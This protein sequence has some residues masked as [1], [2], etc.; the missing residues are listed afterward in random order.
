MR[1]VS[2]PKPVYTEGGGRGVRVGPE[3]MLRRSVLSCLLWEKAFYEDGVPIVERIKA[4]V[5]M[6]DPEICASLAIEARHEQK[7]RHVPLAIALEMVEHV[8]HKAHVSSVLEAIVDRPDEAVEFLSLYWNQQSNRKDKRKGRAV[9][10][11]VKRGL[12]RALVKFDAYQIA[13]WQLRDKAIK[14]R[15]VFNLVCPVPKD[16]HMQAV[17]SDL[18]ANALPA[19]D[20]WEKKRSQGSSARATFTDLI[21]RN[22]LG[23]MAMLKNLRQMQEG[24]TSEDVIRKGLAQA[25]F[26]KVLPFRFITAAIHAPDFEPELEE[27]MLRSLRS[28]PKFG[29]KTIILVDV[30]ASMYGRPLSGGPTAHDHRVVNCP[31]ASFM[32]RA[33]RT[34]SGRSVQYPK[35]HEWFGYRAPV[36][37]YSWIGSEMDRAHVGV[38]LAMILREQCEQVAV[39][40][41]GG[42][43]RVQK[44]STVKLPP[45]RGFA[46]GDAIYGQCVPLG[47]GGIFLNQAMRFIQVKERTADR[48]VVITDEQDCAKY[49]NDKATKAPA[50][51]RYNY[52]IN[53]APEKHGIGYGQWTHIDGWSERIISFVS[54]LEDAG[55]LGMNKVG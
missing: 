28:L 32:G 30:S 18:R 13:K 38:S 24:D 10:A 23:G 16:R 27:A 25:N 12:A 1:T 40:A 43:D 21:N 54:E 9:A 35:W 29:G 41:T 7:L 8:E 55:L 31:P 4:L 20:T 3:A 15:D 11:Q 51:G 45:R 48:I 44:H 53:V 47:G 5:P 22:K 6:V 36:T 26:A 33:E 14:L 2:K 50:F 19:P 52:L 34:H 39:Y 17:Y 42:D 46:L 49:A 37:D